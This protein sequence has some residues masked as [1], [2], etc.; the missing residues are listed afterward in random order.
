MA[1]PVGDAPALGADAA[2][3]RA[4]I[5]QHARSMAA[6]ASQAGGADPAAAAALRLVREQH[7]EASAVDADD[8]ARRRIMEHAQQARPQHAVWQ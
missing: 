8:M 7:G 2:D 1:E 5:M 4:Q 3:A 6:D